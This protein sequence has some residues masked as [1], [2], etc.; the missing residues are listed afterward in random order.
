MKEKET[1]GNFGKKK[2]TMCLRRIVEKHLPI[3]S[4]GLKS[5]VCDHEIELPGWTVLTRKHST[6]QQEQMLTG[7]PDCPEEVKL[8]EQIKHGIGNETAVGDA[9]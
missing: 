2:E 6:L 8:A 5:V 7:N 1:H 9:K 3:G 4:E